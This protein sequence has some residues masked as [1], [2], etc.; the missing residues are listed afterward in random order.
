[1]KFI[2]KNKML[3][4]FITIFVVVMI[5]AVIGIV[6]LLMPNSNKNLYGNRLIGIEK[7]PIKET[8]IETIKQDLTST[9]KIEDVTYVLKGKRADF[10]ITVKSDTDKV[11]AISLTDKILSNLSEEQ[12]NFYD[13]QVFIKSNEE[14]EVFP[15]IGYKH[16]TSLNFAWTNN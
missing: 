11:T 16:T 13:I 7:F 4:L 1:M 14:S 12:K 3:A 6:N 8:S 10:V 5:F 15:I 9:G 2:K